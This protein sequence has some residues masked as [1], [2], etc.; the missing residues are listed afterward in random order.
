[1]ALSAGT[2]ALGCSSTTSSTSAK[3]ALPVT[4]TSVSATLTPYNPQ[5]ASAGIPAEEVAFTVGASASRSFACTVEV[6][7]S[8]KRV[9]STEVTASSPADSNA[10]VRESWPVTITGETFP[11]YPSDARV[12]CHVTSSRPIP[13]TT[14]GSS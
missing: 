2:L 8:G 7:R 5:Y 14:I 12:I 11:G 10:L 9:G 1:M 3:G 13:P 6:W 4:V